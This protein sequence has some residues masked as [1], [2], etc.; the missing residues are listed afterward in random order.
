[1]VV[2]ASGKERRLASIALREF[3]SEHI[4]IKRKR[5][6]KVGNLQMNMSDADFGVNWLWL[7]LLHREG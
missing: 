1:M 5:P 4:A 3:E 6:I 7:L 2:T